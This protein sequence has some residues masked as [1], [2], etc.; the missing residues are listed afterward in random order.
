MPY[1]VKLKQCSAW[2]LMMSQRERWFGIFL[3]KTILVFGCASFALYGQSYPT[4]TWTGG[5][6]ASSWADGKNWNWDNN[7]CNDPNTGVAVPPATFGNSA[8][9]CYTANVTI[10]SGVTVNENEQAFST[11]YNFTLGANSTLN[12]SAAGTGNV[13]IGA[14]STVNGAASASGNVTI[15]TGAIVNG[16]AAAGVPSQTSG[17]LTNQGTIFGSASG[18]TVINTNNGWIHAI[19]ASAVVFATTQGTNTGT[20]EA[21]RAGGTGIVGLTGPWNNAGGTIQIDSG[22]VLVCDATI[23]GGSLINNGG[24]VGGAGNGLTIADT[25]NSTSLTIDNPGGPTTV[26]ITGILNN[27]GD[28]ILGQTTSVSTL[29]LNGG[30]LNVSGGNTTLGVN[31]GATGQMEI[32]GKSP[33]STTLGNLIIGGAG[34]GYVSV[35]GGADITVGAVTIGSQPSGNGQLTIGGTGSGI[36]NYATLTAIRGSTI[37]GSALSISSNGSLFSNQNSSGLPTDSLSAIAQVYGQWTTQN[38]LVVQGSG[39]LT[40]SLA[41]T[42]N[43][44]CSSCQ[45]YKYPGI[46]WYL[47]DAFQVSDKSKVNVAGSG[48]HLNVAPNSGVGPSATLTIQNGA[49]A[50]LG[51]F[52]LQGTA[53]IQGMD[54]VVNALEPPVQVITAIYSQGIFT[55]QDGGAFQSYRMLLYGQNPQ[56]VVQTSGEVSLGSTDSPPNGPALEVDSGG[57]LIQSDGAM[58]IKNNATIGNGSDAAKIIVTGKGDQAGVLQSASITI[59]PNAKLLIEG[60]DIVSLGDSSTINFVPGTPP[61]EIDLSQGELIV[62]KAFTANPAPDLKTLI[63]Y[64]G[65]TLIGGQ[66]CPNKDSSCNPFTLLNAAKSVIVNGSVEN[67]GGT[68]RLDPTTLSVTQNFQQSSGTLDLQMDGSGAGQYDQVTAGGSIQITGGTVEFDFINGFA[69]HSG[70]KFNVLSA[71]SGLSVSGASYTT[72]GLASGF[73]YTTSTSSGQFDLNASDS[74]TATTSAPAPP[75]TP[76]LASSDSASGATE[77]AP[78]SLASGYGTGLATGL[79]AGAT[80]IW[81]TTIGGTSVSIVDLDGV[82]TQAP[83]LYV[84]STEINYQIPDTVALGPATVTVTAADGTTKSGPVN[85]VPSAPGL[86]AVNTSGLSASFADCVSADGTQSTILTSQV[87]NGALVAVPLNLGICQETVLEL[88]ATGLDSPNAIVQATI[89]GQTATVLFAGPEGVYPGVDQV[90]VVI[91]QSLVGAGNVP[92][93]VSAGGLTSNTVNVTIQ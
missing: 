58:Q 90:N 70:D 41:G 23:T 78:G 54:T 40:I 11:I 50:N 7:Q 38:R 73:N 19:G 31:A 53:T 17:A 89:G 9:P 16:S 87:V 26:R 74:G 44:T 51:N 81:P 72:T 14:D 37:Y 77:L 91:P 24:S 34:S 1:N 39:S 10:G 3:A 68:I 59:K 76:T 18:A 8:S 65:G 85:V 61:P 52:F 29:M 63:V 46:S 35:S 86:F 92:I 20:I 21:S 22:A 6:S 83:L 45:Q 42:V 5:G 82:T 30:T 71:S 88:W 13:T 47:T 62:G 4:A 48:A 43:V 33:L 56:L 67:V 66:F 55:V 2:E 57:V 75:P 32:S 79:P 60:S 80:Y 12:G 93:V 49:H 15:G 69:P 84:S 64:P 28:F 27:T 25:V 36:V